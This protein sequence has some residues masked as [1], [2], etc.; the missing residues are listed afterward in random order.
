MIV[1]CAAYV[2]GVRQT[3]VLSLDEVPAWLA[4]PDAIVWLGLRM[5]SAEELLQAGEVLG[6]RHDELDEARSPHV[7]PVLST[8]AELTWLV[9]RTVRWNTSLRCLML[10]ELSLLAGANYLLTIRHGQ[11]SPLDGVRHRLEADGADL[12][13]PRSI[14]AAVL[15]HIVEDYR[16][17]LDAFEHEAIEEEREVLTNDRPRRPRRLVQLKRDVRDLYLAVEPLREPMRRLGRRWASDG[18]VGEDLLGSLEETSDT[19]ASMVE[20]IHSLS[21]LLDAAIDANLAQIGI[22]Q[23]E[24]M[25]KISAWVAMAAVPT[26]LA[27][28]YGMNFDQMPELRWAFGYPF[29]IGLMVLVA[30]LLYRGFKRSGWL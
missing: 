8:Q 25:R 26:L 13:S 4:K 9:V 15:D 2:D 10:G 22:Q 23:N 11:A 29:A 16:P 20:R 5:P 19:L 28:I 3:E 30:G 18:E 27:G 14:F 7:R 1:D 21:G 17:A 6:I 12:A 24:D